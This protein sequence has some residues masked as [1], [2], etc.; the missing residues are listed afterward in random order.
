MKARG[1]RGSGLCFILF[2]LS[3]CGF[4]ACGYVLKEKIVKISGVED[5]MKV[6][7]GGDMELQPSGLP[8]QSPTL[9]QGDTLSHSVAPTSSSS[10]IPSRSSKLPLTSSPSATRTFTIMPTS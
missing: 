1:Y 10:Q 9:P 4:V 7:F 5:L 8:S 2:G 6:L 3:L